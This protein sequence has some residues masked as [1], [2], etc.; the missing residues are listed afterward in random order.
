MSTISPCVSCGACCA[1]FRVSFHW[2]ECQGSGGRV[3]EDLVELVTPSRVAMKGTC[4]SNPRCVSLQGTVGASVTCG[5]Y[6]QRSDPCRDFD[7]SWSA[8]EHNPRCDAA[9]AA[10]GLLPLTP[11]DY[12]TL[13][14]LRDASLAA[15]D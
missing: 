14:P 9:R 2:I 13:I 3:P 4:G 8:G 10:H 5:I 12:P 11:A 7:A 1:H 15:H 6:G